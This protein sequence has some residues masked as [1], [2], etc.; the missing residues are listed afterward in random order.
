MDDGKVVGNTVVENPA[1]AVGA[2]LW[3][4]GGGLRSFCGEPRSRQLR[5]R[6]SCRLTLRTRG[7]S[8]SD[9]PATK[10]LL[11]VK[12]IKQTKFLGFIPIF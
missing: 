2:A 9:A 6:V 3:S 7:R 4:C 12:K 5:I 8:L 1:A 11:V 10:K